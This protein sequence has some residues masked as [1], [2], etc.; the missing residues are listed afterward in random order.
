MR[1]V[2]N[3]SKHDATGRRFNNLDARPG[4]LAHDWDAKFACWTPR[5][6]SEEYVQQAGSSLTR[7]MTPL[8]SKLGRRT[9]NLNGYYRNASSITNLDFYR[10]ADLL[11]FHIVH[12]EFLSVRD[13]VEIAADKPLVWTWHDPYML[14]GHCIYS[15]DCNGFESGCIRCPNLNYHFPIKRDRSARNLEEKLAAVKKLDPMVILASEYMRELVARSVYEN[16]IRVRVVPFGVEMG[17]GLS[18]ADAKR[19]LGIPEGNIVV[20]F[21][22]VYSEYKGMTLIL[23]ALR[24]LSARYP[25]LPITI[26]AFQETGCCRGLSSRYQII[27]TGWIKDAEIATY[28]SAMDYFFMPSKAEA[29][30]LMAIEAMAAGATPIVTVGTALPALVG[31]PIYGLCSEHSDDA[32]ADVVETAVLRADRNAEGRAARQQFARDHYSMDVFCKELSGI[33]DEEVEYSHSVRRTS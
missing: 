29:F 8:L 12:E 22:A 28:Y 23:A 2:L 21:R 19:A 6:E 31:A 10:E 5:T 4:F 27:D 18:Q 1:T 25:G 3:I 16:Q 11:H 13:W 26:I 14:S 20:G 32:Y 7:N 17:S 30:G 9:G 15:L 33:Y 24:R